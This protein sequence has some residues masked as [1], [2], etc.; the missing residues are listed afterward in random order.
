MKEL[1]PS[2]TPAEIRA[3]LDRL[4]GQRADERRP[5][6]GPGTADGGYGLINAIDALNAVDL[7]RVPVDLAGQRARPSPRRPA[8]SRSPSTSRSSSRPCPPPTSTFTWSPNGVTVVV[9]APIAVDNPTD[10][11]IVDF[12]ISFTKI[13]GV[14]RQRRAIRSR[15]RARPAGRSSSSEDGKDLVGS[16]HH[17]LQPGRR[18]PADRRQHHG[19]RPDHHH[20][21]SARRLDPDTVDAGQHLRAH[22]QRLRRR[23]GRPTRATSGQLHQPQ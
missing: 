9:G 16:R 17:R 7:L 19:Q 23:R 2:L 5:R 1:V 10:P 15:S 14:D 11:T 22:V 12:P 8:S 3:G 4:G 13:P 20:H 18:H 6:R 21:S